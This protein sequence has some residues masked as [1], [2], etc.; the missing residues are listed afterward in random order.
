MELREIEKLLERY[1]EGQTSLSEENSLRN[2]FAVNE[3]PEHLQALKAQFACFVAEAETA[4][5]KNK[6]EKELIDL[7]AER[8][9]Q[10]AR[11]KRFIRFYT[12]S[13]IAAVLLLAAGLFFVLK[14]TP[15]EDSFNDPAMAW[16]EIHKALFFV[17]EK[18]NMGIQ[19]VEKA[20][21]SFNQ[22][23]EETSRVSVINQM[24]N[25]FKNE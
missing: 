15:V 18:L 4:M 14:P 22:G 19:P 16:Q 6:A 17:S 24:Q 12:A 2:W 11:R 20:A 5:D 1:F 9:L 21:A 23:I 8:Q 13:G 3:V 25:I 7:I 10:L